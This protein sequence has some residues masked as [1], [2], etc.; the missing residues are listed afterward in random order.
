MD[1]NRLGRHD[2]RLLA[3]LQ[4][5][6]QWRSLDRQVKQILPANLHAHFQ[7]A[8]IEN[9]ALVLLA[10]N[11]MAASRLRM[12]APGLLVRLQALSPEIGSVRVKTV[13]NPPPPPRE[14]RLK[15][16]EAALAGLERSAE[17]LPHHPELAAALRRLA[18]KHRKA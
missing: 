13:P 2:S 8:C 3:L 15:L 1:L 5:S 14:N 11:N 6:Q 16:G 9:G 4:Q 7:T 12:I 10:A 18:E 17:S